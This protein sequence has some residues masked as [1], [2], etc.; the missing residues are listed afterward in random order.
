MI[1]PTLL[2]FKA[3][4][5]TVLVGL[6]L[7]II[8]FLSKIVLLYTKSALIA[9]NLQLFFHTV[10]YGLG[11]LIVFHLFNYGELNIVLILFY[12]IEI[13]TLNKMQKKMLDFFSSKVYSMYI[14]IF[15]WEK[16]NLARKIKSIED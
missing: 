6:S 4:I 8:I 10:I 16:N 13:L 15:N 3:V 11:L 12:V 9:K 1:F 14:K 2:Q 5:F 7:S